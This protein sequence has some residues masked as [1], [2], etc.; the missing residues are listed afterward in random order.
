MTRLIVLTAVLA[1]CAGWSMAAMPA[2]VQPAGDSAKFGEALDGAVA[3]KVP[4]ENVVI[5][6]N[7]SDKKIMLTIYGRGFAFTDGKQYTLSKDQVTAILKRL[8]NAAFATLPRMVG[9]LPPNYQPP[10]PGRPHSNLIRIT[11]DLRVSIGD[12]EHQVGQAGANQS[13]MLQ[14]LITAI[15]DDVTANKK[16]AIDLSALTLQEA[17]KKIANGDVAIEALTVMV[18]GF[19]ATPFNFQIVRANINVTGKA[20]DKLQQDRA[21]LEK[22][23][24]DLAKDLSQYD[25]AKMPRDLYSDEIT[26]VSVYVE[27]VAQ[28]LYVSAR[29]DD[30]NAQAKAKHPDV[31][32]AFEK[33]VASVHELG[34]KLAKQ[35]EKEPD[36]AKTN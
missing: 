34:E 6:A 29:G 30:A 28:K 20:M 25:P 11:A 3:G 21:A 5:F 26:V 14:D 13:Q 4:L 22:V 35:Q 9:T 33:I 27:G 12:Q 1:A 15:H 36:D 17:L 2:P 23:V 32:K 7:H 18:N 19:G 31:Q 16:K 10:P 24:R 8:Q